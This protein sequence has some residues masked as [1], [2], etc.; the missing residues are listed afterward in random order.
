MDKDV[1]NNQKIVR[2]QSGKLYETKDSYATEFPLTIMVNNEEFATVICSPNHLKE[3]TIG[4]LAS[5][6]S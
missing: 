6:V 1:L 2:Y 3:L 5:E 4:F